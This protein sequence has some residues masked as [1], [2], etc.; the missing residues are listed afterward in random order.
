MV[1]RKPCCIMKFVLKLLLGILVVSLCN[2]H[3]A[4]IFTAAGWVIE[5]GKEYG[6]WYGIVDGW[7]SCG[8]FIR[9][10]FIDVEYKA[11]LCTTGYSISFW[12]STISTILGNLREAF[13][14]TRLF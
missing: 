14:F 2:V 1:Y 3:G 13:K 9:S 5:P 8:N 7:I 4:W 6:F 12:L 10:W 11:E